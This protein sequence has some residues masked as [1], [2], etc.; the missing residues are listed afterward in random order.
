MG[1]PFHL[2]AWVGSTVFRPLVEVAFFRARWKYNLNMNKISPEDSAAAIN[3]P[4]LLIHGEVD[5][6]IP[7]RHSRRI[8]ELAHNTQ[9]WEV[10]GADHCAA[11]G[12]APQEFQRR[13]LN[14]FHAT[15]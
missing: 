5:S 2:H 15:P 1:Q 10:P 9:L 8:H 14:W 4:I 3:V 6:N 13:V 11:Y 12:T 7:I